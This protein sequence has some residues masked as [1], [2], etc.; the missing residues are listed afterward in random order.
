MA[1][2]GRRGQGRGLNAQSS[3]KTESKV[4]PQPY[5][6]PHFKCLL[7]YTMFPSLLLKTNLIFTSHLVQ[8]LTVFIAH[9]VND[10]LLF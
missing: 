3:T 6:A 8:A 7:R 10:C 5:S 9:V 1:A 4:N 2:V